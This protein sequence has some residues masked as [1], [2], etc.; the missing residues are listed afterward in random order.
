MLDEAIRNQRF[1]PE[2][3]ILLMIP[4]SGRFSVTY[5]LLTAGAAQWLAVFTRCN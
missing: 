2:E 3:K 5:A 4:E 1:K